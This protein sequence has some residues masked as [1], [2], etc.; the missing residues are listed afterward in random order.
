MEF[1]GRWV[2]KHVPQLLGILPY[3]SAWGLLLRFEGQTIRVIES[4]GRREIRIDREDRCQLAQVI[5]NFDLYFELCEAALATAQDDGSRVVDLGIPAIRGCLWR[6]QHVSEAPRFGRIV[7]WMPDRID[8]RDRSTRRVIRISHASAFYLYDTMESFDHYF[9]SVRPSTEDEA[10]VALDVVDFSTPRLQWVEGFGDFEVFCP[11][12]AEPF[13]VCLD[14]LE[15][16]R[17]C[18]GDVVL[19]LGCYSG[20]TAIAFSKA[21]GP[22]GRVITLEPDPVNHRAARMNIECHRKANG[23]DNITLLPLAVAASSGLIAFSEEGSMGSSTLDVVGAGRGRSVSVECVS[24]EELCARQRLER[25]DFVKMDIEGSEVDVIRAAAGFLQA[26]HPRMVIEPHM[27]HGRR[28]DR[29]IMP[30]LQRHGYE[31]RLV[32]QTG[33]TL[34]LVLA[35]PV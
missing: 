12:H 19:D 17:L 28:A 27:V 14:Y 24:L 25:V 31:C 15:L 16:A 8:I 18:P 21:V 2:L 32:A 3:A 10:G 23:L 11:S 29:V 34:P 26:F 30:W 22:S 5:R 33:Y 20:L 9:G 35:T 4:R 7:R 13:R 1:G 6:L